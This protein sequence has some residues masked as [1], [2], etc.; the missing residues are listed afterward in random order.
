MAEMSPTFV[1]LQKLARTQGRNVDELAR[2]YVLEGMLDRIFASPFTADSVLKGGVLLAAYA[3]RRSTKDIDVDVSGIC[4]NA[5]LAPTENRAINAGRV[6]GVLAT[7]M[8]PNETALDLVVRSEPEL[9]G[10]AYMAALDDT[11]A[12]IEAVIGFTIDA[13]GE[14]CPSAEADQ[15]IPRFTPSSEP[16]QSFDRSASNLGT[17]NDNPI[18][19][20]C[21]ASKNPM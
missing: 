19:L 10:I 5:M 8:D 20:S 15:R 14:S 1:R 12:A 7:C 3:M 18:P 9:R 6:L 13:I 4:N 11:E 17:H 16:T 21:S 2:S